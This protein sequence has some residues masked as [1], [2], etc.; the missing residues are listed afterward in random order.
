MDFKKIFIS[1]DEKL[2]GRKSAPQ[3]V[4]ITTP[5]FFTDY[6]P[7]LYKIDW[8]SYYSDR[9]SFYQRMP[10]PLTGKLDYKIPPYDYTNVYF[11]R[12]GM[13]ACINEKVL[14]IFRKLKVDQRE[15][16]TIPIQ[17]GGVEE[18]YYVLFFPFI[19]NLCDSGIIWSESLFRDDHTKELFSFR[20]RK[21]YIQ[22][23]ATEKK[24]SDYRIVLPRH[25]QQRDILSFHLSIVQGIVSDRIVDAFQ[26][27][28]IIGAEFYNLGTNFAPYIAFDD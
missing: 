1:W 3:S 15:Y 10:V 9:D 8:N 7:L 27:E 25:Y 6:Y 11:F 14:D 18:P 21:E 4:K 17:I 12:P 28:G 23:K 16:Y 5:N 20:D 13:M 2:V 26:Q 22:R 24:F 19:C